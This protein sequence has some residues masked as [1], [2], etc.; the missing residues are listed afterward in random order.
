MRNFVIAWFILAVVV[1]VLAQQTSG[2]DLTQLP[3]LFLVQPPI[4]QF[5]LVLVGFLAIWLFASAVWQAD[6]LAI[7]NRQMKELQDRLDGVR[8]TA[9]VTHERQRE[10]D[11]G[12]QTVLGSDPEETLLSLHKRL[13]EA[14]RRTAQQQSRNEAADL[15]EQVAEI[16]RRQKELRAQLGQVVDKR[17][18]SEP[19]F[20]ELKERQRDIDRM[21]A[22]LESDD[23]GG[24]LGERLN[25]ASASTLTAQTRLNAVQDGLVALSRLRDTLAKCLGDLPPL[26]HAESG[27]EATIGQARGLRDQLDKRLAALEVTGDERLATRLEALAKHKRDAEQ[28][29]AALNESLATAAAIRRD[30]IALKEQQAQVEASLAA[31]ETDSQGRNIAD[32]VNEVHAFMTQAQ[33]RV[34]SLQD[35]LARIGAIKGGLLAC[36]AGL[37]PLQDPD[38]GIEFALGEVRSLRDR[39][40]SA[41]ARLESDGDNTLVTHV[42]SLQQHKQDSE[43]R[44]AALQATFAELESMRAQIGALFAG[45]NA[46]LNGHAAPPDGK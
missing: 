28:R 41:L 11:A 13:D 33:A 7:Q 23:R 32:R 19:I 42:G 30:F 14:E 10:L 40:S 37:V 44:V 1:A 22:A 39:L 31:A 45:L 26:E 5:T 25:E 12:V 3:A 43:Q 6:K 21:L 8:H 24:T 18:A 9:L 38:G 20:G 27:V 34:A 16:Q 4:R 15:A 46:A 17:R 35:A 36:E 29:M 2:Y